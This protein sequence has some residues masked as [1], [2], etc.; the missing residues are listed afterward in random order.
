MNPCIAII[1]SNTLSN[2]ALKTILWDMYPYVEILSYATMDEFIRDSNRHFIYFFVSADIL[3]SQAGEFEYLKDQTVV[4]SVG[5]NRAVEEAGFHVLDISIPEQELV[6]KLLHLHNFGHSEGGGPAQSSA[7]PVEEL[8][9]RE[10]DVLALMVKG[11]INKEI[12]EQLNIST[13]TVIFHRNNICKKLNTRSLG[14][15][16]IM[17]VLGG[18]VDLNE[19]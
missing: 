19:I 16:T 3:F 17:A 12:S 1:D 4:M 10:K 9:A 13:T 8:S 15:M 18:V 6:G 5:H 7:G 2:M 14:K 11:M